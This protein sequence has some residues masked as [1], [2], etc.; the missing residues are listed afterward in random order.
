MNLDLIIHLV[1]P[2]LRLFDGLAPGRVHAVLEIVAGGYID[3]EL[4]RQFD[5][6]GMKP[7]SARPDGREIWSADPD[8]LVS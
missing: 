3:D 1:Q 7:A 8:E 4:A 5:V 6:D 2:L